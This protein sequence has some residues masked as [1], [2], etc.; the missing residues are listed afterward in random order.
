[1]VIRQSIPDLFLESMLPAIDEIV[2]AKYNRWPPQFPKFFRMRST[3]RGIEQT[4]EMTG[5]GQMVVVPEN[6]AVPYATPYPAFKKTYLTAQYALGFKVSR[7]VR[8]DDRHGVVA[9]LAGELGESALE[10]REVVA[11][12]VFNGGFADTG[13]DGVSLFSTAHPLVGP[14]GGTQ[15]N[16]LSAASDP[17]P[18]SIALALTDMRQTV[19][20]TGK[21]KRIPPKQMIVPSGLEFIAAQMLGGVDDPSTANRALNPLRMRSGLPSFQ[22]L[23]VWEY[24][25]DQHAW[26]IQSDPANTELRF[27]DQEKFNTIHDVDFD[28]R[29][30]K[31]A[32]WMRFAVGHNGF[33]GVYGVPSS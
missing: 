21:K 30:L 7:L 8:D 3:N 28:S 25:T 10:T 11:A 22:S 16:C 18:T 31:T 9:K 15:T 33:Y 20:H 2:Q 23:E 17:D 27:Y 1:M 6:V 4:T 32:G 5:F 24:L 26:F 14:G 12:S 29:T 19:D 13:P